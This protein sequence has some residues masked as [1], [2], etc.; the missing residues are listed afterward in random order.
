MHACCA[1]ILFYFILFYF[2]IFF[3]FFRTSASS[4]NVSLGDK[5][6]AE[7]ND[8]EFDSMKL[9]YSIRRQVSTI[10]NLLLRRI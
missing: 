3:F 7:D 9:Y 5:I 2:F 10:C 4:I 8:L 1:F 6:K